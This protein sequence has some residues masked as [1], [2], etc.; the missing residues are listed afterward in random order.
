MSPR[1]RLPEVN[2]ERLRVADTRIDGQSTLGKVAPGVIEIYRGRF[3]AGITRARHVIM[4][5]PSRRW[6]FDRSEES[7][8]TIN[9]TRRWFMRQDDCM[10]DLRRKSRGPK[11]HFHQISTYLS[12]NRQKRLPILT[13]IRQYQQIHRFYLFQWTN[14]IED[15]WPKYLPIKPILRKP[16]L[17][18]L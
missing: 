18:S 12:K 15:T 8:A 6:E 10:R 1:F 16:V 11:W 9:V 7:A 3:A 14:G 5:F 4:K 17:I 2:D 13:L